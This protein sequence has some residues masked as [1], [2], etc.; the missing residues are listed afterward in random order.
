[1]RL[2]SFL[3]QTSAIG[4]LLP[5]ARVHYRPIADVFPMMLGCMESR[6]FSPTDGA[7]VTLV[8]LSTY[9]QISIGTGQPLY[10]ENT[11]YL[12]PSGQRDSS[13]LLTIGRL[14]GYE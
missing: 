10:D 5:L 13:S 4:R 8:E 3:P 14:S 7:Q 6:N 11:I 1:M 12:N 9:G 2:Q